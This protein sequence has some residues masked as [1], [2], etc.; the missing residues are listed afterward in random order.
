MESMFVGTSEAK[1]ARV[2]LMALLALYD[3]LPPSIDGI[4]IPDFNP[5]PSF[6]SANDADS[7]LRSLDVI[8]QKL[9]VKGLDSFIASVFT[10]CH[11]VNNMVGLFLTEI[12]LTQSLCIYYFIGCYDRQR[13]PFV[14]SQP[15]I[16]SFR[17]CQES[18]E[19]FFINT[20][21]A[22]TIADGNAIRVGPLIV[23]IPVCPMNLGCSQ[24]IPVLIPTSHRPYYN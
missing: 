6:D 9:H 24:V 12:Y 8:S 11:P 18:W 15:R 2:R 13:L 1:S 7:I 17:R 16:S 4:V 21:M 3:C 20:V 22:W 5:P 10:A 14:R 19:L 23:T